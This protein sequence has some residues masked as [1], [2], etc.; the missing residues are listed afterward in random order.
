MAAP[1]GS[2]QIARRVIDDLI[3]FSGETSIDGY[4]S[5]FKPQQITKSRGFINRIREEAN[6]A[7][8]LDGQLT[9]LIAEMEALEDQGEIFYTLMDLRDDRR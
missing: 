5:F 4:I 2:N 6:T 1:G 7:R 3:K 9:N 8:N